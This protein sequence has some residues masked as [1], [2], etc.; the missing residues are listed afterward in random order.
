MSDHEKF[1][2][3]CISEVANQGAD[4]ALLKMT[5]EWVVKASEHKYSYH[6]EWMGRP[7]IQHPQDI[8]GMQEIL[9]KV[10]PDLVIETGVARG[11]S[12]ILYASLLELIASC[13]GPQGSKVLGIDIDIRE[14]NRHAIESHPM[15][16]RI[17]LIQGSSI[18][19]STVSAVKDYAK[20]FKKILLCLDS[21]HTHEHVLQELRLYAPLVSQGSYCIVFDTI[22][23]DLPE[24]FGPSRPW[25]KSNN[26]KTAVFQYLK[27]LDA[28]SVVANDGERLK[29]QI[30]K[31]IENKLLITVAPDGYL[32]RV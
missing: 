11:G 13:G 23:E 26:P 27:E 20:K 15:S 29:L 21:N 24:G 1:Q 2:A 16:K 18:A 31:Q 30:D 12:L 9:W 5:N 32:K 3:D 6:F 17:D 7:I 10:Q 22:V 14:H 28:Q 25:G 19:D 4:R 8:V